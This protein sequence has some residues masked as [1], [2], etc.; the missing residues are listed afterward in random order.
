MFQEILFSWNCS[1]MKKSKSEIASFDNC[2][3][4]EGQGLSFYHALKFEINCNL[5]T[6]KMRIFR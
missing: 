5:P 2:P 3:V 4:L 1:F 6:V